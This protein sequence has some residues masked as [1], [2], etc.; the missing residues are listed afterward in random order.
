MTEYVVDLTNA[1]VRTGLSDISALWGLPVF[2]R[3][4][5]CR[6]CRY[7]DE[8]I[9]ACDHPCVTPLRGDC[10]ENWIFSCFDNDFCAWGK[11]REVDE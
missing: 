5:R 2:E 9:H 3:I 10:P 8:I 7:Y 6:D 4:V 1:E 11:P